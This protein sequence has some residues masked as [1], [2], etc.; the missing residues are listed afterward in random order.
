MVGAISAAVIPTIIYSLIIWW[1]DRYEKEPIMLILA[2]FFWGA[3][4]AIV[5]AVLFELV[6]SIPIEQSP[7]GP[8]AANWG[9]APA[10]EEGLKAIALAGLFLL[11]RSEF[12]GPLDGIVYGALIGFGFSMTENTLYFLSYGDVGNLFWVRSVLFGINHGFFTSIVGL[13]FGAVRYERS[14]RLRILTILGGLLLAILFHAA[15]NFLTTAFLAAGMFFSWLVQSCGVLV[16][17][18]VA[19]LS[20]RKELRWLQNEL[21]DEVQVGTIDLED[22][23]AVTSSVRR[24]RRE[25]QALSSGGVVRFRHMRHLHYS[26]TELAFC[27][28]KQR[29]ADRYQDCDSIERLRREIPAIRQHLERTSGVWAW[30]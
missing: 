14:P 7:L 20:W 23:R 27:K 15:H 18:A 4:P 9:L 24:L 22:Y 29:M 6:F 3:I 21:C 1:L 28:S 5:L 11:A 19:V 17:L 10:I 25:I 16:V 8:N 2:A 13:A 26:I 12:D 30:F